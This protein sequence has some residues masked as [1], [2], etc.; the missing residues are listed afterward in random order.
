MRRRFLLRGLGTALAFFTIASPL[1]ATLHSKSAA[2]FACPEDGELIDAAP[3]AHDAVEV[4]LRSPFVAR[5]RGAT[6][7][8]HSQFPHDHCAIAQH[9]YVRARASSTAKLADSIPVVLSPVRG[10]VEPARLI[11]LAVY[12]LA[13]KASPPLS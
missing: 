2:H 8:E 11:S 13:P 3:A 6:S 1:L 12:R 5:D 7:R 9:A 4:S 10:I